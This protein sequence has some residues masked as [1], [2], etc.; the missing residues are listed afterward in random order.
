MGYQPPL[1]LR[2][3]L[4]NSIWSASSGNLLYDVSKRVACTAN[5]MFVAE[6]ERSNAISASK[7]VS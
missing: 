3:A 1:E 6:D 4:M 7:V 2:E 5:S